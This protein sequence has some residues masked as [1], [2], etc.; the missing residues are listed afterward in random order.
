MAQQVSREHEVRNFL[1]DLE[2]V[3]HD[4]MA[5]MYVLDPKLTSLYTQVARDAG[6]MPPERIPAQRAAS[7]ALGLAAEELALAYERKRVGKDF[8]RQVKHVA[9]EDATAGYDIASV[10]VLATSMTLPRLIEV[11]AVPASNL[12]FYWSSNEIAMARRFGSWYYLYLIPVQAERRLDIGS[13]L[14]L[15]NPY[16]VVVESNG[17]WSVEPDVLRCQLK[18]PLSQGRDECNARGSS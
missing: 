3:S 10:T 17:D 7:E 1:M 4:V 11:K 14:I 16:Q 6:K 5:D 15:E 8:A 12:R 2:A 18:D 9:Q 13:L